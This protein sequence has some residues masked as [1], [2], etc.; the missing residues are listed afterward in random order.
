MVEFAKGLSKVTVDFCFTNLS[1]NLFKK[2]ARNNKARSKVEEFLK[3]FDEMD[4]K[5]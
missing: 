3:D 4:A 2:L 1:P 5:D